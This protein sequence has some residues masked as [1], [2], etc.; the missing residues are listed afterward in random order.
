MLPEWAPRVPQAKIRR[1]YERDAL[2]I[3]DDELIDEVAYAFYGRCESILTVTRA[4]HGW[5][6]CPGCGAMI[7][8]R[9]GKERVIKCEGCGWQLTW[10]E[11]LATYQHRKLSGG[12]AR[13]AFEEYVKRLPEARSPRDKML[14]IDWLVHQVHK[15]ALSG[16]ELPFWRAAAVNLIEGNLTQVVAFL[17]ELAYGAG[18]TPEIREAGDAWRERV[19]PRLSSPGGVEP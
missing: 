6:K 19:L 1:L 9:G 18:S 11:Y 4:E 17:Q 14:L 16:E 7:R 15:T 8:R 2:G 10:G 3:P 5:V 13:P 12:S